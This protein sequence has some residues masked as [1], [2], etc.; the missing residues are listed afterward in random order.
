[1]PASQIQPGKA[2]QTRA[3]A[4]VCTLLIEVGRVLKAFRFYPE[5]HPSRKEAIDRGFSAWR[6]ELDR[7]GEL[8]LEIKQSTFRIAGSGEVI[9]RGALDDLVRE[10]VHRG[11]RRVVFAADADREA[12]CALVDV[13]ALDPDQIVDDGGVEQALYSRATSGVVLNA[14]DYTK[15][16]DREPAPFV[17]EEADASADASDE[18]DAD[19]PIPRD[20]TLGVDPLAALQ[21]MLNTEN[22]DVNDGACLPEPEADPSAELIAALRH[23]DE[24]RVDAGYQD[25]LQR[26][27]VGCA[28]LVDNG[29]ADDI[30]RAVLVLSSHAVD[31]SRPDRQRTLAEEALFQ[32]VT[33]ERIEDIIERAC[34]TGPQASVRATQILLQLGAHVVPCLLDTLQTESDPDRRGQMNAILI[35]MGAKATPAVIESLRC[36]SE[37]RQRLAARL[38]G[39]IQNPEAVPEL[40]SLLKNTA[41]PPELQKEVAKA[42]V[43]IGSPRAIDALVDAVNN[44][45][46]EI[47]SVAAFC[48]GA[49]NHPKSLEVLVSTLRRSIR[50]DE[51][52]LAREVIRALGR[53]GRSEAV[54][55]L[56]AILSRRAWFGRRRQRELKLSAAAALARLPGEEA[57]ELL[58]QTIRR[59]DAQLRRAAQTALDRR[60]SRN[61]VGSAA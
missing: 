60:T 43:R 50:E 2:G 48:L 20:Q 27:S 7:S 58:E 30:Y 59:G 52:N 8:A 16:L 49:T 54:G 12:F 56:G 3:P 40:R 41:T 31:A 21:G 24:C 9:G 19:L 28:A 35:A 32:L 61:G 10:F 42:L 44:P 17:A 18:G 34:K 53:L 46:P 13:L 51:L 47:A 23:L 45:S 55:E 36:E 29:A 5:Q 57:Q 4:D 37:I 39:E 1:M 22:S 14:V 26:V 38:A 15:L 11:V 6:G 25:L 33:S